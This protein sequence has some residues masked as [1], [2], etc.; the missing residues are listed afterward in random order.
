MILMIEISNIG[1]SLE[2]TTEENRFPS[3][4]KNAEDQVKISLWSGRKCSHSGEW[5]A[6]GKIST[7]AYLSKGDI[8]PTYC[9]KKVRWNLLRKG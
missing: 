4:K 5:E 8:M 6:E 1:N 3:G 2:M 9:E 7:V